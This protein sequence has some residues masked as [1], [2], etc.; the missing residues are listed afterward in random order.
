MMGGRTFTLPAT[1]LPA[2]CI[3]TTMTERTPTL[4]KRPEW[5]TTRMDPSRQAWAF[6][7]TTLLTAAIRTSSKPTSAT[8]L[9]RFTSIAGTTT[10]TTSPTARPWAGSRTGWDGEFNSTTSTTVDGPES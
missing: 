3:T 7:L 10:L 2:F 4:G 6:P 8:I 5:H 1:L 9:Q